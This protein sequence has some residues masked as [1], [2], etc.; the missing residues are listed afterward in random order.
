MDRRFKFF[1]LFKQLS[2][3]RRSIARYKPSH[4]GLLNW[5]TILAKKTRLIKNLTV[6]N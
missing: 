2:M 5:P 4:Y 1:Y 3:D 6:G